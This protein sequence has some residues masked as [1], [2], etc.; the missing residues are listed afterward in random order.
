MHVLGTFNDCLTGLVHFSWQTTWE[1]HT[2]GE[3]IL[4]ILEGET[5]PTQLTPEGEIHK[6]PAK[7]PLSKSR[8]GSGTPSERCRP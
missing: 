3:E 8:P 1:R 2:R 4:F 7:V 5:E 6:R